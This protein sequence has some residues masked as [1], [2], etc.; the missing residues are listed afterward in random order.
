MQN[1]THLSVERALDILLAFMEHNEALGTQEISL[2]M[3]LHKSTVNR[4]MHVLTSRGFLH[5]DITTRKFCLGPA[6][7]HLGA[8]LTRSLSEGLTRIAV[9]FIDSLRER[10]GETVVFETASSRDTV[11]SYMAGGRGPI[12][13]KGNIGQRHRYHA[14][15]GAKAILA[16]SDTEFIESVLA[17]ELQ[18]RTPHTITD[19]DQLREEM[20]KVRTRGFSFEKE[21][22]NIGISGFG[23]PIFNYEDKPV[24]AVV[25][26]GPNHN[27]SWA[28]RGDILPFL[29]ETANAISEQLYHGKRKQT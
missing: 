10:V 23:C 25:I 18:K 8:T 29:K 6:I 7:A 24:A 28:K 2:K 21:E 15:A 27:V 3:G 22:N 9:P 17:G 20:R 4:L 12:R 1:K 11:I 5:Q 14:A 13:I 26:A 19:K 16:F